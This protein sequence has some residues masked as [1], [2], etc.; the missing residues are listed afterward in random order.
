MGIAVWMLYAADRLLDT[1]ALERH[2]P[3]A[4][5]LSGAKNPRILRNSPSLQFAALEPRHYFHR[6]HQRAFR[7]GLFAA[8][9]ILAVLLPS[10]AP[11][12]IRLYL[13]LGT[14]VFGYFVIIHVSSAAA[15]AKNHRLPKEIAV[16]IFFSAAVFI[17]TVARNPTLRLVLLPGA[18]LFAILCCMNCL[19]IYAWEHPATND[20]SQPEAHPTTKLA[21]RFLPSLAIAA[22]VSSVL[23]A[24]FAPSLPRPIPAACGAASLLLFVLHQNHHRFSPTTLRAAADLCLLTPLFLLLF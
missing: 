23:L 24:L 13:A 12:S 7:I 9:L 22:T 20:S 18:I 16:G 17:P 14:L 10:L 2:T 15:R 4:V 5:I 1:R 19:F 21:L 11:Q 3:I 8:S 6:R